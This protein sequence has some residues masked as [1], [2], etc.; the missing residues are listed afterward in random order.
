[1]SFCCVNY[2]LVP[3]TTEKPYATVHRFFMEAVCAWQG[4]CCCCYCYWWYCCFYGIFHVIIGL[5]FFSIH[6]QY[7]C[8]YC[9]Y[10]YYYCNYCYYYYY[11]CCCCFNQCETAPV[12]GPLADHSE[13][14]MRTC[15]I[16]TTTTTTTTIVDF[17]LLIIV[18]TTTITKR[19]H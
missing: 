14:Y 15:G 2:S 7:Y 19:K 17:L 16:L 5:L 9:Y 4:Y 18:M 10:C 12:V 3:L 6:H 11:C 8:Y 1:M 13:V